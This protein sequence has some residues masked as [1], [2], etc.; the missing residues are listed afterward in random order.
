MSGSLIIHKKQGL[1]IYPKSS[2]RCQSGLSPVL[3]QSM[4]HLSLQGKK[5]NL[6]ELN[7]DLGRDIALL[8]VAEWQRVTSTTTMYS[9]FTRENSDTAGMRSDT[10][11]C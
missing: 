4:M 6:Y 9:R 7:G 11:D 5:K 10:A 2:S 1:G 8:S 3:Q